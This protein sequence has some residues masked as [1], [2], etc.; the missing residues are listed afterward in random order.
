MTSGFVRKSCK[1][2]LI[3][4]HNVALKYLDFKKN[5]DPYVHVRMFNFVMK[6]NALIFEKFIINAS[7]YTLR[8]TTSNWCHNYMLEFPDYIFSKLT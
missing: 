7:S 5:V 3:T 8:H 2:L 4:T 1:T 6:E